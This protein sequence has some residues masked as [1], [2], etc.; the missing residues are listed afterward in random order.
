MQ[1]NKKQF[2]ELYVYLSFFI[3]ISKELEGISEEGGEQIDEIRDDCSELK[4]TCF[5]ILYFWKV[6]YFSQLDV[7]L[8]TV[9]LVFFLV[10]LFDSLFEHVLVLFS[11]VG[12]VEFE[13]LF[14]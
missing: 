13:E 6:E 12:S 5:E 2:L 3:F 11:F 9:G 4:F 8:L 14:E 7:L 10:V 1:E